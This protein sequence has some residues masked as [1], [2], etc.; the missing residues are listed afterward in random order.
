VK[1]APWVVR[2]QNFILTNNQFFVITDFCES[3]H[4]QKIL[5]PQGTPLARRGTILTPMIEIKSYLYSLLQGL[6]SLHDLGI[7]HRDIKQGNFLYNPETKRGVIIDF[8]LAE[9][10]S[11]MKK[12]VKAAQ[13]GDEFPKRDLYKKI[14]DL[15]KK[16][17]ENKIGTEGFMSPEQVLKKDKQSY[18][19]DIWSAGVVFL[20]F[21]TGKHTLFKNLRLKKEKCEKQQQR[22]PVEYVIGFLCSLALVFGTN[23]VLDVAHQSGYNIYLPEGIQEEQ[24]PWRDIVCHADFDDNAMDL[25]DKMVRLNPDERISSREALL[26]PYFDEVRRN[27]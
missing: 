17:G 24:I 15:Q 5:H 20:E 9:I 16:L 22:Q 13:D 26:H 8:G 6:A 4:F 12:K 27:E 21:L 2:L 1:D 25:L 18:G 3:V 19:V 7:I 23:K 10:T 11:E 14:M